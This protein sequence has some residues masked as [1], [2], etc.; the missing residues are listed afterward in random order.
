M[1]RAA[2]MDQNLCL[3]TMM[4]LAIHRILMMAVIMMNLAMAGEFFRMLDG[5]YMS[6]VVFVYVF[7]FKFRSSLL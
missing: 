3:F 6:N 1:A 7:F 4:L 2:Y 5:K